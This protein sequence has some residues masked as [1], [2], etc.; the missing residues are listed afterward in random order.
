M[1]KSEGWMRVGTESMVRLKT[2]YLGI[3]GWGFGKGDG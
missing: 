1:K 3:G 2:N